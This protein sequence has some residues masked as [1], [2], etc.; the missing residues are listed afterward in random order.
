MFSPRLTR[1]EDGSVILDRLAPAFVHVLHELPAL[2][3]PEQP[4]EVRDRLYPHATDDE[5]HK[6]EWERFVHPELFA[7]VASAREIVMRDLGSFRPVDDPP[8]EGSWRL[9]INVKHI[10]G[11]ISGLNVARLTL[12]ARHE[13]EDIDMAEDFI[14]EEWDEKDVA[15]AQIHLLAWLQQLLIEDHHPMPEEFL[16]RDTDPESDPDPDTDP[17]PDRKPKPDPE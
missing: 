13:I 17:E 5:E 9:E 4:D 3:A 8:H 1:L 16:G 6:K 15:I 7:L 10:P 11:W 12:G 14:P 2:L